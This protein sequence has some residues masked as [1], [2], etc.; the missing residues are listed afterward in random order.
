MRKSLPI[1]TSLL[2]S[3]VLLSM[4]MAAQDFAP[5]TPTGR[6]LFA[7]PDRYTTY[8]IA[9]DSTTVSGGTTT[10]HNYKTVWDTLTPSNCP[11]WG[12]PDCTKQSRPTWAGPRIEVSA[13]GTHTLF[14]LWNEPIT[15]A[16]STEAGG[17][18][19]IYA[20]GSQQFLLSYVGESPMEVL[21]FTENVRQWTILHEDLNGD[22]IN[23]P[24]N[25]APV[26][27]GA[28][29]GLLRYFRVDSFPLVLQPVELV[30]QSE[31]PLGLHTI[32]PAFLH[33]YQPGDEVQ[34][35]DYANYYIG[36]PWLDH[37]F[38]RKIRILSRTDAPDCVNYELETTVY[39]LDSGTTVTGTSTVAY[40]RNE[41]IA[42]IPFDRFDGTQPF[43]GKREY[44]GL[45]LW[46]YGTFLNTG[47]GYCLEENC[48]GPYDTNGP[49]PVGGTTS[50]GGLGTYSSNA[51]MWNPNGY[52]TA[53]TV[54]YFKKNGTECFQEVVMGSAGITA[55]PPSFILSPNP[56]EGL[57]SIASGKPVAQAEVFDTQGHVMA[58]SY[59]DA[60][61]GKLDMRAAPD[62]LYLV[63]LH[64]VD[65]SGGTQ[66]LVINR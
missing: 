6:K 51:A 20:D 60:K 9:F 48:W 42:T 19:Q 30:G 15:L 25:N 2:F 37:D 24:L 54:V 12:G 23:S 29:V 49:P 57:V 43:L 28:T 17:Q 32:T 10:Y 27:V 1:S 14:N 31:P 46:T 61:L 55:Q 41:V 35:H 5:F 65:G 50:V 21:G 8:G 45:S 22:P 4:P 34:V 56:S 16:F 33:D 7:T 11:W 58:N 39:S 47:L 18:T 36:P 3:T 26:E 62:G 53:A 13:D 66:R 52:T 63:R 64:F 38:Y 44:C 40:S 59:L